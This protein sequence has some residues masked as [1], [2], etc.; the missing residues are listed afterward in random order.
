LLEPARYLLGEHLAQGGMA[1]LFLGR[2]V[3][4]AGIERPVV[5]KRLRP[6]LSNHGEA[7][8][9]FLREAKLLSLLD[10]PGIV[11]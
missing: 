7:R 8:A 3:A 11:R 2:R 5:L 4:I 9:L 6:E 10:H 1:A